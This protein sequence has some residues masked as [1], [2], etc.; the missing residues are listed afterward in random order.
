MSFVLD[1]AIMDF[2][3][4]ISPDDM[5]SKPGLSTMRPTFP[6]GVEGSYGHK[7]I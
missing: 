4:L 6:N 5:T 7:L 2:E 3:L 1:H